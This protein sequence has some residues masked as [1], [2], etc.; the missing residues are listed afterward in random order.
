MMKHY[1]ETFPNASTLTLW[2]KLISRRHK[3]HEISFRV[4]CRLT[5]KYL[6]NVKRSECDEFWLFTT[7]ICINIFKTYVAFGQI[8]LA[9]DRMNTIECSLV[10]VTSW[11]I[12]TWE[13]IYLFQFL[14]GYC[15]YPVAAIKLLCYGVEFCVPWSPHIRCRHEFLIQKKHKWI[16]KFETIKT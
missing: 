14:S 15:T 7:Y 8:A 12:M 16:F 11:I 10:H 2:I 9:F 4:T 5:S 3:C 1:D 6:L 13:N